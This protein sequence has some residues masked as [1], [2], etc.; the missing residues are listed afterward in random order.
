M[1]KGSG[2]IGF[3]RGIIKIFYQN[4]IINDELDV[5]I[6]FLSEIK[7]SFF[8]NLDSDPTTFVQQKEIIVN[9]L[10]EYC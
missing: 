6:I 8:C 1:E 9:F 7:S 2:L 4:E 5:L 3:Y 10:G